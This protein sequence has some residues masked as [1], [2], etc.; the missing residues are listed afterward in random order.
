MTAVRVSDETTRAEIA[1][2]LAHVNRRA[3]RVPRVFGVAAPSA[4]DELHDMLDHLLDD[5]RAAR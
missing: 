3:K 5:W 2:A 1:E 4:W